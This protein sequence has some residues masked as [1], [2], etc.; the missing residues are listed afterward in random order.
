VPQIGADDADELY[1]DG[2]AIAAQMLDSAERNGKKVTAGNIAW[3]AG[4]QLASGRRSTS[5]GRTD[6]LSPAAQ[7]DGRSQL[8]SLQREA[9]YDPESGE[10]N[11]SASLLD[12]LEDDAED[13]AQAAARNI[14]WECFMSG[15]DDVSRRMIVAFARGDTM[16]DLKG[17]AG[18]SDSGMSGRKRRLIAELMEVLGPDCLADAG[19]EPAWRSDVAAQ[20][21]KDACRHEMA[22]V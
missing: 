6:V 9:A 14:D 22:G 15:L 11:E 20:R 1:Q 21:E 17:M 4:K 16:R 10:G 7:L 3:Y 13:P 18:L 8:T 2:L 19:R 5:G 12:L